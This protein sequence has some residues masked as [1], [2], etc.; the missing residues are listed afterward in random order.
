MERED[1]RMSEPAKVFEDCEIPGQWRVEGFDDNGKPEVAIFYGPTARR[2]A[3]RYAMREYGHFREV[4]L[5]PYP[6][7]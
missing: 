7:P 3:L 4:Q 2:L 1:A 6:S 5:E